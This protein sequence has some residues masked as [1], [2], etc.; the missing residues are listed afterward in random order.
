M[1]KNDSNDVR[2]RPAAVAGMFYPGDPAV[3]RQ[4]V[5]RMLAA[6]DDQGEPPKALI[7]PHAGYVY[8]GQ[9]AAEVYARLGKRRSAIRRVVL[10][11]PAHRVAFRGI[12]GT[13]ADYFETPLGRVPV[14]REAMDAAW[15]IDGV[16]PADEAHAA[17]HSLEVQLPFLQLA[18]DEFTVAPFVVGDAPAEL[19]ARLLE[20]LW[21]G[22]ETLIVISSDLSHYLDYDAARE[23]DEQ[24]ARNIESL[25]GERIGPHDACGFAPIRGLLAVARRKGLAVERVALVNSGDTAGDKQ[26]VVGYGAYV[27]H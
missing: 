10:L 7:A 9:A 22:D 21:G 25:H 19:T 26:R 20:A 17:E 12:A 4:Q 14:D 6:A 5:S 15:K 24:T 18:L 2:V 3:L 27:L 11:G 8:S 13:T 16:F 23:R 1:M